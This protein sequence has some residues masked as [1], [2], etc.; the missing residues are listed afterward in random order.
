M[1]KIALFV[2]VAVLASA[3]SFAGTFKDRDGGLHPWTIDIT[4]ALNWEGKPYIPF[5]VGFQPRYLGEQTDDNL[6]ADT[7]DIQSFKL[8]GAEDV[9]IKPIKGI[10]ALPP[11]AFQKIIDLLEDNGLRYGIELYDPEYSPLAGYVIEPT[12]NRSAGIQ[13]SG[14]ISYKF[15]GAKSVLY[16]ISDARTGEV[17]FA[18]EEAV[19]NGAVTIHVALRTAGEH[20]VLLYP[21]KSVSIADGGLFD[22]WGDFENHR[23]RLVWYL[24]KIKFGKG[25]RFLIDPFTE[26][27][28]VRGEA[29][30]LFPIS[31][32]FRFEYAAWLSRKYGAIGDLTT[33]WRILQHDV[34]S[35][36]E[37]ARLVPLWR[38]SR[39]APLVNDDGGSKRYPV[40]ATKSAIWADMQEFQA[41]SLRSYMDSLADVIKRTAADVP[42][43]FTATGLQPFFQTT[44]VVGF[45][46]LASPGGKSEVNSGQA[47]SL[48]DQSSRKIWLIARLKPSGDAFATKEELFAAMNLPRELGAKGFIARDQAGISGANLIAWLGEYSALTA[49]DAHYAGYRPRA[50]YYPQGVAR[51][52]IR[53][54]SNGSWWLPSLT[55]GRDLYVG[56]GFAGYVVDGSGSKPEI[57]VWSLKGS[58]LIHLVSQLPVTVTNISGAMTDVKPK[59]GRVEISVGEEPLLI[60]GLTPDEFLPVEVVAQAVLDLENTIKKAEQKRMD[61]SDY[62]ERLKNAKTMLDKN[63]LA[64][65]L[66]LVQETS[67]ELNQRLRGLEIMPGA[68]TPVERK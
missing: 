1:R 23:D 60:Q 68:A 41:T 59:K 32:A 7:D 16:A 26:D 57:Y 14:D 50:I 29:G 25:L 22:V 47:F 66:A 12:V 13:T 58:R 5:A 46:G 17:R 24:S 49:N 37:A 40:D 55:H 27:L 2:F 51:A 21:Q 20:V 18:G 64:L 36:D 9:V 48:A 63:Q 65:C 28:G 38:K 3:P 61:A 45:D 39:G 42:V 15:P 33:A 11:E 34:A 31:P 54:L 35:F 4:H 43:V 67:Q 6:K 19:T 30:A 56:E 53:R 62:A 10:S 44:G 8:A 52:S